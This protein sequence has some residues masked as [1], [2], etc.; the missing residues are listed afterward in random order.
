[1]PGLLDP[2]T[3]AAVRQPVEDASTL[4]PGAYCDAEFYRA[5]RERV[6]MK[7]WH[8]I[9]HQDRV[10]SPGSFVSF[11]YT[12]V[13]VLLVHGEDGV[14]RA[15]A[16]TCRH[17]GAELVDGEGQGR[18]IVCPYHGWTYDLEG[19]LCAAP[20]MQ[21]ARGF[22]L[23]EN[24]LVPLRVEQLGTLMWLS[25]DPAAAPLARH[26]GD[27]A[28]K[29]APYRLDELVL[30]RR[31]QYDVAC[32]W[33]VYVENF[34]DYYH[35]PIVHSRTLARSS[36]SV[37][38]RQPPSVETGDGDYLVLYARHEGSAALLPGDEGFGPAKGLA[39][40][41]AEGSTF[42][43]TFPCGLLGLTKDCVWYIEIHPTGPETVRI[44]VGACFPR[45]T[46]SRSDFAE[47]VLP[48]YR[49]WDVTVEEDNRINEAQQRGV[50]SPLAR[51]G[52]VSPFE[53]VSHAFRN[54]LLD[55]MGL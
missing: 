29:L 55:A 15:F 48:Y 39:G 21:E 41:A 37:Y 26:L 42:V 30:A 49:R 35:T 14:R 32:N 33:K 50:R 6:F 31:T 24:G 46:A 34:M 51:A 44:A 16:N 9:G 36:L 40:R 25:F 12:G 27:L 38:H 19:R 1:V 53:A 54:R 22:R 3:Y 5:E 8:F 17:R 10:A 45:E 20:G 4:P 47:R 18:R 43:C 2:T 23:E 52:R 28:E 11:D 7:G 13:P